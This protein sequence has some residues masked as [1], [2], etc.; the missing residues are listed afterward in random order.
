MRKVIEVEISKLKGE[1]S[2]FASVEIQARSGG[3]YEEVEFHAD[4][5]RVLWDRV[6]FHIRDREAFIQEAE[7]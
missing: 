4:D 1:G 2:Y 5:L 7:A 6:T 3:H